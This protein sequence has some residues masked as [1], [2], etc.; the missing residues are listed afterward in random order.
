[1]RATAGARYH[2]RL[3]DFSDG[4]LVCHSLKQKSFVMSSLIT[5]FPHHSNKASGGWSENKRE[6]K[7]RGKKKTGLDEAKLFS[8]TEKF[9]LTKGRNH[10]SIHSTSPSCR[11]HEAHVGNGRGA[12]AV[13]RFFFDRLEVFIFWVFEKREKAKSP[14]TWINEQQ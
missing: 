11:K 14:P 1:M 5:H 4:G 9:W 10:S 13:E 7:W 3:H 6:K 8:F 12:K 2:C